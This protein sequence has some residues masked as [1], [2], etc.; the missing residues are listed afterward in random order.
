M[1]KNLELLPE[2]HMCL[3]P[4]LYNLVNKQHKKYND[5]GTFQWNAKLK[6]Q[7]AELIIHS[8]FCI[9]H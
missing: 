3:D 1:I 2:V 4:D 9:L 8:A 5:Q 6:M 7:N